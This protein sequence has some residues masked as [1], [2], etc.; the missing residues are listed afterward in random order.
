MA[1]CPRVDGELLRA[2]R[3]LTENTG[4]F[5]PQAC[6]SDTYSLSQLVEIDTAIPGIRAEVRPARWC[7]GNPEILYDLTGIQA[8]AWQNYINCIEKHHTIV[9]GIFGHEGEHN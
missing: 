3:S 4:N 8:C 5:E 2:K 6:C 1:D 9:F 7:K